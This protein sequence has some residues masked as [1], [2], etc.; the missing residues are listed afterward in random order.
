MMP[1]WSKLFVTRS[2]QTLPTQ[3]QEREDDPFGVERVMGLP[4][5]KEFFDL[6]KEPGDRLSLKLYPIPTA[7]IYNYLEYYVM[8]RYTHETRSVWI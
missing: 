7:R 2:R 1:T 6:E 3:L 5:W 8:Y 4:I